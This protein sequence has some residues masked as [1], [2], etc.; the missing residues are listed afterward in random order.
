MSQAYQQL[1]VSDESKQLTTINTHKSLFRYNRLPYG[2]SSAPDIY[3][4]VM[5]NLLKGIPYV[6]VRVD[7]ILVL[8]ESTEAHIRN[9]EEVLQRLT[10]AGL[11]L[12][13]QKCVFFAD[14]VVYL[15]QKVTSEGV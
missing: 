10:K 11:R 8:G 5:D 12:N 4:R 7:N 1:L 14:Q 13:A 9:L 6:V 3:Q 2:I 15:G